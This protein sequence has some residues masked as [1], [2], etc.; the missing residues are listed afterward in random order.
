MRFADVE[1]VRDP[2]TEKDKPAQPLYVEYTIP[3]RADT[4]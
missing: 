4:D 3:Q 1:L 2:K